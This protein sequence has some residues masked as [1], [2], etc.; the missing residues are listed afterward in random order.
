MKHRRRI[1]LINRKFQLKFSFFVCSW[2]LVLSLV[3]PAVL[4]GTVEALARML[5]SKVDTNTLKVI[6]NFQAE[7]MTAMILFMVVFALTIFLISLF[8]SHRIAGPVYRIQLA[9]ER[10][11]RGN[12]E[13]DIKLRKADHFN[14]LADSYN[15][16]AL[17]VLAAKALVSV[18]AEKLQTIAPE[19]DPKH[20]SQVN[21]IA[22]ELQCIFQK[23]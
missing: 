9:L 22:S 10:M 12:I 3:F 6:E 19:L 13:K 17:Q 2:V 8:V 4:Y 18:N 1:L 15:R 5:A 20:R 23:K 7:T 21:D 14:D 16:A 11:A